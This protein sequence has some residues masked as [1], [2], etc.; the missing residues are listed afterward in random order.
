MRAPSLSSAFT[1]FATLCLA[2]LLGLSLTGCSHYRLGT[3]GKLA[4]TTLYVAPIE[5][6]AGLPQITAL[7]STQL[8]ETFLR[9][10]RVTLVDSPAGA[11]ATLTVSVARY[12]RVGATGRLDDGGLARKF[13][14]TVTAVCTLTDNR[15]GTRL[16]EKRAIE[17][18]RQFFS[19]PTP[20]SRESDQLQAEY[21]L[22]P[23]LADALADRVAHA[24][25]D[26]W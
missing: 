10:A 15:A 16:F 24:T 3:E 21:N 13:N 11:D 14:F 12:A 5:N 23:L 8:R 22:M 4:F 1:R 25:L 6:E 18:T 2:A 17:V 7:F 20:T 26:V 9:D 19:T